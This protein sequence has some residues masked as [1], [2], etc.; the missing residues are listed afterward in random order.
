MK[1]YSF[2]LVALFALLL[3]S[4]SSGGASTTIDVTMTDFK[5][6]PNQFTVPAGEEITVN[7]LNNGAVV[8]NFIIMRLGESAEGHFDDADE[9]NVYWA[10]VDIQPGGDL[11]TAFTAPSEPG[12]YEIVC[13]TEGHI[14]A[15]MAGK[16]IVVAGEE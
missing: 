6:E 14:N 12:E 4:C 15:G 8:H 5:F 9:A 1:K 13:R 3:A 7:I 10:E 16:L 2:V 11:Q